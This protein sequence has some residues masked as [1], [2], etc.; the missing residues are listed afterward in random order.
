MRLQ[1]LDNAAFNGKLGRIEG[2]LDEITGRFPVVLVDDKAVET[3]PREIR[4]KPENMALACTCCYNAGATKMQFCGK[5]RVAAYCNA[6]CQRSDWQRHKVGCNTLGDL[7]D[8]TKNSLLMAM[9]RGDAAG[10]KRLI[11][12]GADINSVAIEST[13]DFP[14]GMAAVGGHL[15]VVQYLVEMGADKDT[16][17]NS[18]VTPLYFAAQGGSL[19]VVQ[20]LLQ[21]GADKN[22]ADIDGMTP[23]FIAASGGHLAVVRY[24]VQQAADKN[25][26]NKHGVTALFVAAR[27]GHLAVVQY[28]V[29][30]GAD[31]NQAAG[32]ITPLAAATVKGRIEVA[33]YLREQGAI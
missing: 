12:Q 2:L 30:E 23:L 27:H 26:A 3:P 20:Y 13:G 4:V 1:G 14:L 5:C 28:L 8:L 22:Q 21:E 11:R 15:P 17:N 29:Q 10:V 33:N 7:R 19:E 6:E 16:A 9:R 31:L 24:L 18:G 25:K 32:D